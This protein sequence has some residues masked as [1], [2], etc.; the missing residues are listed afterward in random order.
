MAADWFIRVN[1]A[2]RGP[3]SSRTLK[4][5]A[6]EGKVTPE[7]LLKKGSSGHW[8]IA[9]CVKGLFPA[10]ADHAA[11]QSAPSAPQPV[12]APPA[13]AMPPQIPAVLPSRPVLGQFVVIVAAVVCGGILVAL[14]LPAIRAFQASN[15]FEAERELTRRMQCSNNLKQIGL[16]LLNY[17]SVNRCFPPAVFADNRGKPMESWRVAILPY[18]EQQALYEQYDPKQP[19][20]SPQNRALGNIVLPTFRCPSDHGKIDTETNYVMIVGK[21][22]LGGTPNEAVKI[23]DIID[24]TSNTIMVVEVSG[25]G[26]NWEEPRNVSVDEFLDLVAKSAARGRTG[27]HPG[28][29]NALTADGLVHFIENTIDPKTLR[30]LLLYNTEE[31]K[32]IP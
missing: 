20:D 4:Q 17:D 1:N 3:L 23:R 15:S 2:D 32:R 28:G 18:L 22:T 31:M 9:S 21:D 11:P 24:G 6:L 14:M 5:L 16:A 10:V 29:F 27:S 7:T 13:L 30:A 8:C 25:L 12:P 26:I 19:W